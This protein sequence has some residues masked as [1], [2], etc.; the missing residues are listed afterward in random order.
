MPLWQLTC[1]HP[2]P[3]VLVKNHIQ[4]AEGLFLEHLAF[5]DYGS[6]FSMGVTRHIPLMCYLRSELGLIPLIP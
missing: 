5:F 1:Q 4:G 2:A 3:V 6:A